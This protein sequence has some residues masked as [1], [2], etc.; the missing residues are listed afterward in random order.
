MK[1]RAQRVLQDMAQ[2]VRQG[3]GDD[4]GEGLVRVILCV[5]DTDD[6]SKATSTG[7]I[8]G[9]IAD[10]VPA[11]GGHV[12]LGIT[13]HQLLIADDVPY[14]SHNSAMAFEARLPQGAASELRA[15]AI[16]IIG[17]HRA[18]SSDPGLC[19]AVLPDT[20]DGEHIAQLARVV[21]FGY[22]AK[23]DLCT[24]D[25]A[26]E[27]AAG[28]PWL[29]LSEHGGNGDGVVGALAGVGLRADG[30]DGRF[31]GKWV[32]RRICG[33]ADDAQEATVGEVS[34][35]LAAGLAGHVQVLD[36]RGRELADRT[37][38]AL[39]RDVKP[40]LKDGRLTIVCEVVDGMA[41][42]CKKA[43]L[44]EMGNVCGSW[45]QV[46]ESFEWDNDPEECVDAQ[47]SCKNCLYRRWVARGFKCVLPEMQ[48]ARA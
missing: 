13:R 15:R 46:C 3:G 29:E 36:V 24:I 40:L 18:A 43:D 20:W 48:A 22:R 17:S 9:L 23:E 4:G 2:R 8:A 28:V 45:R 10:E 5:D 34:A 38:L 41:R 7:E 47:P 27:L 21:V 1:E 32:L 42:P 25:E 39:D 31:R 11:L 14:T 33:F 6:A 26:Y 30:N 12:V 37:P 44:G 19:V 16:D 35:R